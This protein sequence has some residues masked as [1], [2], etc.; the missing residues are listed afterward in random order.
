MAVE[1]PPADNAN[2]GFEL[3]E[4]SKFPPYGYIGGYTSSYAKY[5]RSYR[6]DKPDRRRKPTGWLFP[7][8][9]KLRKDIVNFPFGT[10]ITYNNT[11]KRVWTGCI[12]LWVP[13]FPEKSVLPN[14]DY[15][16]QAESKALNQFLTNGRALDGNFK[17]GVAWAER[18]ETAGLLEDFSRSMFNTA[19][20]LK[21]KRWKEAIN[22]LPVF[23]PKSAA[24]RRTN[25]PKL[26]K[27][28][29]KSLKG[30]KYWESIKRNQ[31]DGLNAAPKAIASGV[32]SL[33]NGWK[34]FLGDIH[35]A[36]E[37]LAQRNM[38]ADWVITG[39]GKV[40]HH[41]NTVQVDRGLGVVGTRDVA[42]H[43]MVHTQGAKVRL[44][45]TVSDQMLHLVAQFGLNNPA[46]TAWEAFPLTYLVD[47]QW[48][49]GEYLES[50][51][52][53][54]G[55]RF[56]SGSFTTFG[57]YLCESTAMDEESDWTGTLHRKQWERKV[58]LS[59]PVPI[60]PL[61][62]KPKPLTFM[63]QVNALSVG[64]LKMCGYDV[65]FARSG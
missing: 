36:A 22:Y 14:I 11:R 13:V 43:V 50:L 25:D 5:A 33:Q 41:T 56:L 26:R 47:Y 27:Q 6:I 1:Q 17:A 40:V 39:I 53:A 44:D 55:M 12:G 31:R 29:E 16:S 46:A 61:S 51:G 2:G 35:N 34:P 18:K 32:L 19:K 20:A 48:A 60:P 15:V 10:A 62:L 64:F 63:Q 45:A 30:S 58:Y 57:E 42:Q 65:P 7:T 52:A 4:Y 24:K 23:S 21:Q 54:D 49:M 38:P 8:P 59:F 3:K 37:A 28:L 9:Y